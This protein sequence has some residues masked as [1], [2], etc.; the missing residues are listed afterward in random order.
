MRRKLTVITRTCARVHSVHSTRYINN[1]KP[2]I[3]NVCLSS[4]V[5]SINQVS[6]HDIEL[7]V[8]DD[9]STPSCLEDI[10]KILTHCK[11]PTQV[12]NL[13]GNDPMMQRESCRTLM[14]VIE[15]HATDLWYHVEDD[16]LHFPTAIQ[17]MIDTVNSFEE[18][19]GK[20]IAINPHDDV[21]RYTNEIYY[22]LLLLGPYR[23]YRTVL[24]TTYTCLASR[25]IYDKYRVHFQDAAEN[26]LRK[27]ENDTINRVWNKDDV[28][29]FSPIPGI[30]LHITGESGKD[31]YIDF[32]QLWNS[33]PKLWN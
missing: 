27:N 9:R 20:M 17:D 13:Q 21:W 4:L 24:H 33:T 18:Y 8:I 28:M 5:N 31:P 30:A 19:T 7:F 32:D 23:H 25:K 16:Y 29:L 22:S 6:D 3:I 26:V 12:I 10:K 2:E 14:K 15:E 1:S 11:F